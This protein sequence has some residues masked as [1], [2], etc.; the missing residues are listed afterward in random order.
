MTVTVT[1][2]G[3]ALN[4]QP[5]ETSWESVV[6]GSKL[7]GTDALGGY[8]LHT[9]KAPVDRGGTASWNW[10]SYDNTVLSTIVTHAPFD[11]MHGTAVT[12]NAGVVSRQ[13]KTTASQPGN[14]V[15]GVE[16]ELLIVV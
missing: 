8:M 14:I 15:T 4:P 16:M 13:I 12:Y 11:T 6:T 3:T 5:A 1:I 9:L 2:N 10:G 7:N